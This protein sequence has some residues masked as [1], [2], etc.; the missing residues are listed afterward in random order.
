MQNL[1]L[2][3]PWQLAVEA[4]VNSHGTVCGADSAHTDPVVST[5]VQDLYTLSFS[6]SKRQG[7]PTERILQ[8]VDRQEVFILLHK[9][10][11]CI[12]D[13]VIQPFSIIDEALVFSCQFHPM[14]VPPRGG[15]LCGALIIRAPIVRAHLQQFTDA[16]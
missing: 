7:L 6:D 3:L 2:R 8:R 10:H 4:V 15:L 13:A 16:V 1:V 9:K 14:N 11:G 5:T 12:N